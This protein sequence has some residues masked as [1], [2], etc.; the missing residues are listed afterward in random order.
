MAQ[1]DV[2]L[3]GRQ[4]QEIALAQD[5]CKQR[6]HASLSQFA[7]L[8]HQMRQP[9]ML[10]EPHHGAAVRRDG[11]G[12]AHRAEVEQQRA[13]R[14]QRRGRRRRQPRQGGSVGDAPR[15]QLERQ[16]GE[17][18]IEDLRGREGQ[19]P[20]LGLL[21]PQAQAEA[22]LEAAG[23]TAPLVGRGL[24]HAHGLQ[25]CHAR[26]RRE[27]WH[28]H[29]AGIDHEAHAFDRQAGL[30][31]R[32]GEHDLAPAGGRWRDGAVLLGGRQVA[33]ERCHIDIGGEAVQ[34]LL[35]A[36][37]LADAGQEHQRAAAFRR[38]GAA[39]RARHRILDAAGRL[40]V[41]VARLDREQA[42][43]RFD[44]RR[45]AQPLRHR[46]G[47]E[48]RRHGDDAQLLAQRALGFAY[49]GEG[50]VALQPAL[51]QLV[52]DHAADA[53]ERRIVL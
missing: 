8:D 35:D 44:Q 52:E 32:G 43:G 47:I 48:R 5:R 31:D 1:I 10:A 11:A 15:R 53:L 45:A 34:A 7:A 50:E 40:T 13:R 29:Q 19:Q 14:C 30:G 27:A 17:V 6:R 46:A 25:P 2:A 42:A 37:D 23:T 28:A 18:G 3:A 22:G 12:R 21:G 33:V 20:A 16:W 24:V 9:R 38:D 39:D 4:A 51:V 49:E 26:A 36:A 41:E